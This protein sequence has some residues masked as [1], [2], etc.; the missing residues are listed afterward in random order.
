MGL[1]TQQ[2]CAQ[3][4]LS[5]TTSRKCL[6]GHGKY[7]EDTCLIGFENSLTVLVVFYFYESRGS[8]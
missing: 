4:A 1:F 5:F 7:K 8:G 3:A 6:I 2:Y